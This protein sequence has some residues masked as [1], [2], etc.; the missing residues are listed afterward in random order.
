LAGEK[1]LIADDNLSVL[2]LAADV[3]SRDGYLVKA[4]SSSR[5]AMALL[6]G[7]R[8]DLLLA[9]SIS[10]DLDGLGLIRRAREITPDISSIAIAERDRNNVSLDSLKREVGNGSV[11]LE[12]FSPRELE[13]I[14]REVLGKRELPDEN[15]RL[16][17]LMPLFELSNVL[18]SE[19]NLGKLFDLVVEIVSHETKADRV[20]LMLLD[21]TGRDLAIKAAVGLSQEVV[22]SAVEKVGHGI[23]GSVAKSG[24]PILLNGEVQHKERKSSGRTSSALCVPLVVRGKVIGVLNSSK[25]GEENRFT[26]S[27][28]QLL[29]ILA[30][31]AAIAIENAR[32][33]QS[34][35]IQQARLEEL[36]RE[37][38][39]AQEEERERISAEIHD[40]V[41]QWMVSA[42]YHAQSSSVLIMESKLDEACD[43]L[44]RTTRIIGQS[45]KELRRIVTDLYPPA[46][47]ELGLPEAVRQNIDC[48]RRETGAMCRLHGAFDQKLSPVHEIVI[49]RVVQEALNNVRKHAHASE[50]DISLK[51]H[52]DKFVVEIRDDGIGFDPTSAL[53]V[54]VSA[55]KMGLQTMKGRAEMLGGSLILE[56]GKGAGTRVVLAIP[57]H[58]DSVHPEQSWMKG[59][60][61]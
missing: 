1:I 12:P 53:K 17:M 57:L 31:Q 4:V 59:G 52:K 25:T 27:D 38:L 14:V 26:Q 8:F 24:K 43:E 42:S 7:E 51:P 39:K 11:L 28:L 56:S 41:A 20:S 2:H 9:N 40:S 36:L 44:E 54:G 13:N 50:V 48:F 6:E 5:D 45:I 37:L 55:G 15:L 29:S 33:F 46:L 16:R 32:L 58:S 49:Y 23:A 18:M 34:V 10:A 30:G 19:V 22:R 3:L 61:P 35:E 47:S 21:E 60:V